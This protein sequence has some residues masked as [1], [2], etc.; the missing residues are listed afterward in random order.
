M[1]TTS[2]YEKTELEPFFQNGS[3][4]QKTEP[5]A[6]VVIFLNNL[7]FLIFTEI[8]LIS[9]LKYKLFRALISFNILHTNVKGHCVGGL[10][11]GIF[12]PI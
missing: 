9:C 10:V 12:L 5:S 7:Q 3:S 11:M 4:L 1:G 2:S 6:L 8:L